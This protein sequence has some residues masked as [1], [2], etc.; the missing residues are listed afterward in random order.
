MSQRFLI[1]LGAG[2]AGAVLFASAAAGSTSLSYLLFILAPLPAFLAGLGW[3][4]SAA[5]IASLAGAI[6]V[7][8]VTGLWGTFIYLL[9]EGVPVVV[10][11]YL[12][13][14]NRPLPSPPAPAP[15][16]DA[17][18]DEPAARLPPPHALEWYPIGRI[19]LW[20]AMMA[21]ALSVASLLVMGATVDAI[22]DRLRPVVETILTKQLPGLNQRNFTPDDI[23]KLTDVALHIMPAASAVLWM[24]GLLLN[25]WIAGRITLLSGN[26]MRP[27]PDLAALSYPI[28]TAALLA[29]T[30]AGS[31]LSGLPGLIAAS[32]S[33]AIYTAYV[34]LGLAILH[35]VTR[36]APQRPLILFAA[37]AA[38][39]VLNT[40]MSLVFVA[41]AL[42]EPWAPWRRRPPPPGPPPAPPPSQPNRSPFDSG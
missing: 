15:A 22:R 28:G 24:A 3:G 31:F 13:S 41:V 12:A 4:W 7:G 39:L 25:L 16:H 38:L 40:W 32:F 27:W 2:L 36:P 8:A 42:S 1:G 6:M 14:L 5:L 37:Y 21:G 33:G 11:C 18:T 10:L 35:W 30:V 23:D 26:L 9:T 20:A 17:T 29:A 19:V 34:L